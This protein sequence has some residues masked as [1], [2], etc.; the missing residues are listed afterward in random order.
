MNK[1]S[2]AKKIGIVLMIGNEENLARDKAGLE[3][4]IGS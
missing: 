4:G 3:V 2:P 1:P